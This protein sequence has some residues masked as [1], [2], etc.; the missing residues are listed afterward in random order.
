MGQF[1]IEI[2]VEDVDPVTKGNQELKV[3]LPNIA[4]TMAEVFGLA[5]QAEFKTDLLSEMM[6]RLIPEVLATKH[7]ALIG[8]A[9]AKCNASYLGYP[10]NL[11]PQEYPSNF[12]PAQLDNLEGLLQETAVNVPTPN[13]E[14]KESQTQINE[15]LLFAAG[16]IKE[17]FFVGGNGQSRLLDTIDSMIND[18]ALS[19]P[20]KEDWREWL[21]RMNRETSRFNKDQNLSSEVIE[22]LH[23]RIPDVF[24]GSDNGNND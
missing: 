3:K 18:E 11:K 21:R 20:N 13:D 14:S 1:P 24:G 4:E 10:I 17:T 22:D 9:Y 19:I 12:N 15:K 16:I 7:A 5:Y 2:K 6:L 8:Q 23:E